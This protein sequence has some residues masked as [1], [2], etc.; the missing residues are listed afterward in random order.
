MLMHLSVSRLRQIIK[1]LGDVARNLDSVLVGCKTEAGFTEKMESDG[2][3]SER[4]ERQ[5]EAYQGERNIQRSHSS[6]S[7]GLCV[8]H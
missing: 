2:H 4:F 8:P 1:S 3:S 7:N 5:T 6:T